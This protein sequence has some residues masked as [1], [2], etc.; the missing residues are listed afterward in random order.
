VFTEPA[1]N[2]A[3]GSVG[4]RLNSK[5]YQ[6]NHDNKF[7]GFRAEPE[8]MIGVSRKVMIHVAAY[9]SDMFQKNFR[10][11]G[12]SIYGKYRFF[13]QDDVHEHFR[14][15][16]Y[17]KVSFIKNP[18]VLIAIHQHLLPDGMGG[19]VQHDEELH[20]Q[21]NEIDVDGNNSGITTGIVATKLINKLAVSASL[22]YARRFNNIGY[23]TE[24]YQAKNAIT[25]TASAG[26][27]LF[28]KEYT[29]YKQTNLNLYLEILGQSFADKKQSYI[30]VA[31]AVQFIFNSIARVDVGYR[32]QVSGNVNR[33]ANNYFMIRLEYNLLNVFNKK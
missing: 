1:S 13:S 21:S 24:I 32:T 17:A 28:P 2:M 7:N 29:S 20:I 6:M 10:M 30:D 14:M 23:E 5:L 3:T 16:T 22:G 26:Y 4:F 15:A 31:P 11:E 33:L 12:A 19:Y 27:L 9:G 18:E 25:Y 8:I